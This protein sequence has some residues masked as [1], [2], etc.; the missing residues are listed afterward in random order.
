[1]GQQPTDE[2]RNSAVRMALTSGLSRQQVADDLG[3]GKSTLNKW[4]AAFRNTDG[5]ATEGLSLA[6]ENIRLRREN[7]VLQEDKDALIR[8][9]QIFVSQKL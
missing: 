8:A 5:A 9:T 2:F 3:V 6:E 4:I 7:R 1:M